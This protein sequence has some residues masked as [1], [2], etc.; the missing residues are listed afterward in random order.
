MSEDTKQETDI[1]DNIE[2]EPVGGG[3][4]AE[5]EAAFSEPEA[6]KESETEVGKESDGKSESTAA[7]DAEEHRKMKE[8]ADK[9][10]EYWDRLLRL[11]AEFDNF[12]KRAARERSQA[13][14]YANEALLESLIPALDNFDM[15]IAAIENAGANSVDSLKQGVNMV[16]KQLKDAIRESGM[17][18]I[19]AV[20]Q[21][22]NYKWH[23][24]V[25]QRESSEVPEG[26]VIEQIRKGYK[27]KDRLIRPAEVIVAKPRVVDSADSVANKTSE[28]VS[29]KD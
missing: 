29:A 26:Q 2:A 28:E 6:A 11:Q 27:L 17:E 24:A 1:V 10:E 23:E 21:M 7:L 9:A 22:F 19:N 8:Q 12:K 20:G 4:A 16:F 5:P 13:I 14:K 25:E 18:E 3:E 15:A